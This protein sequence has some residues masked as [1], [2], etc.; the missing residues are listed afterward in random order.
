[1]P[2]MKGRFP[3]RRTKQYLEHGQL[4]LKENIHVVTVN[5][6]TRQPASKGTFDFV[7]WY[8]PQLQYKNP[9]VQVVTFKNMTPSPFFQFFFKNGQKLIVDADS[10]SKEELHDF[11]KKS[12]CKTE[13]I[14]LLEETEKPHF[15]MGFSRQCICEIPG[16]VPCSGSVVLPKEV[17]GKF[18]YNKESQ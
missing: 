7:W 17:R 12:M 16:Q 4:K 6:N 18:S 9:G 3:I 2:F 8:L 15:G 5:Y 1:M 14:K 13:N 11:I 10:K